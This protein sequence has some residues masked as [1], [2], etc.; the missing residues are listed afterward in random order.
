[1]PY[2]PVD[3]VAVFDRDGWCCGV[4]NEPID[5]ALA[6]PEPMSVS[7]DH[8]IPMVRGGGHT[9][10]NCQATHLWCNIMKA[11]KVDQ[12]QAAAA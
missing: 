8:K 2:E 10:E 4:C 3:R 6:W 1:M 9:E 5:K 12:E 7:L 11:A